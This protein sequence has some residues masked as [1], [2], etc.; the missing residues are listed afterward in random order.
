V[1]LWAC[2]SDTGRPRVIQ[3]KLSTDTVC[4]EGTAVFVALL[5]ELKKQFLTKI[6]LNS[7]VF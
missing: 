6:E 2:G 1:E 4:C 7:T 5:P 3:N